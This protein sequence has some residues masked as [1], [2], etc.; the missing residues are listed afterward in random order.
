MRALGAIERGR[1]PP[2]HVASS[3][4]RKAEAI[5]ASSAQGNSSI[6]AADLL[7]SF[8]SSGAMGA[9]HAGIRVV[10]RRARCFEFPVSGDGVPCMLYTMR[11][12]KAVRSY[13]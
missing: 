5:V 11:G 1:P 9:V 13:F 10:V 2:L 8:C 7:S 6:S 4:K 12:E 3:G